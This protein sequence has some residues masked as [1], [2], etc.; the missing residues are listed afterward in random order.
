MKNKIVV[1]L[2]FFLLSL[3]IIYSKNQK[4]NSLIIPEIANINSKHL[5]SQIP[6]PGKIKII[7][8]GDV[9]PARAVN[10]RMAQYKNFKY[11]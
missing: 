8:T 5:P 6:V 7:I 9:I 2:V 3:L 11:P 4:T 1:I 10:A